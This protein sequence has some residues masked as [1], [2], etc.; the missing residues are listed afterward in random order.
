[1]KYLLGQFLVII[2]LSSSLADTCGPL[3]WEVDPNY[4]IPV[5]EFSLYTRKEIAPNDISATTTENLTKVTFKL[6]VIKGKATYDSSR[7]IMYG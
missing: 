1:M 3:Y 5:D 6:S 4:K 7:Q 2:L